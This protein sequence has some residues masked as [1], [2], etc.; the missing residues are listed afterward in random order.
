MLD[1]Y[2]GDSVERRTE[3]DMSKQYD[4]AGE[5]VVIRRLGVVRLA[6]TALRGHN[7]AARIRHRGD[8]MIAL[9]GTLAGSRVR[10]DIRASDPDGA[11][12]SIAIT[13]E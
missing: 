9:A 11:T 13:V 7:A 12:W 2:V 6:D 8:T 1:D 10:A 4:L 5:P 3:H